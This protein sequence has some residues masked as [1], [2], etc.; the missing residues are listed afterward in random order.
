MNFLESIWHHIQS[1]SIINY[2]NPIALNM[3]MAYTVKLPDGVTNLFWLPYEYTGLAYR[4]FAGGQCVD[5]MPFYRGVIIEEVVLSRGTDLHKPKTEQAF[6]QSLYEHSWEIQK[7]VSSEKFQA[8]GGWGMA[9]DYLYKMHFFCD[10]LRY[11][12]SAVTIPKR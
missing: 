9:A 10:W 12:N 5:V 2:P 4:D 3:G 11:Y 1:K 7:V 6:L 8:A